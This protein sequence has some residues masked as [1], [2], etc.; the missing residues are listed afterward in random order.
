MGIRRTVD[1]NS[2]RGWE[3]SFFGWSVA[4][5]ACLLMSPGLVFLLIVLFD[6][7]YNDPDRSIKQKNKEQENTKRHHGDR[8]PYKA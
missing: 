8:R 5:F 4:I 1:F 3:V 7:H 6:I 2:G